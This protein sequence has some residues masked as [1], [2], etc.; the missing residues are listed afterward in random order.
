MFR[1]GLLEF[2]LTCALVALA[3]LIPVMITRGFNRLDRRL[4]NIESKLKKKG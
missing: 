2:G 3:V 4:K 1:I